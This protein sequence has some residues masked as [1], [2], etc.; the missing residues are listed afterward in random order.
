MLED[1][2]GNKKDTGG[3]STAAANYCNSKSSLPK[4]QQEANQEDLQGDDGRKR[5]SQD[6]SASIS[7]KDHTTNSSNNSS[8]ADA[9]KILS[10]QHGDYPSSPSPPVLFGG[11]SSWA[12]EDV[13]SLVAFAHTLIPDLK[14]RRRME[15]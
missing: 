6:S 4:D 13:D 12:K 1:G 3:R 10:H 15:E 7:K 11:E 5:Q 2:A 9:G 8:A 14:K